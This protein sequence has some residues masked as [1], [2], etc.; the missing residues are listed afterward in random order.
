MATLQEER[1][2]FTANPP[3]NTAR[4]E[5]IALMQMP[6][7]EDAYVEDR[8][9]THYLLDLRHPKG[10]AKAVFFMRF[11]FTV[12]DWQILANALCQHSMNQ[13]VIETT[14]ADVS[15]QYVIE[16]ELATPDGRNPSIR[17]VWQT[18]GEN[19]PRFITAY[20]ARRTKPN[21]T[22]GEEKT[23]YDTGT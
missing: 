9:I 8:K 22:I 2:A 17:S 14:S 3:Q 4:K 13:P 12:E 20:P 5:S 15:V 1:D 16:G 11:G 19:A 7:A 23:G 21:L 18:N 6:N 10:G